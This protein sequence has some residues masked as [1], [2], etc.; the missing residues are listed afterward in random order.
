MELLYGKQM[1]NVS[2]EANFHIWWTCSTAGTVRISLMQFDWDI[3][4]FMM[5]RPNNHSSYKSVY[6]LRMFVLYF[7]SSN[8][9]AFSWFLERN[10]FALSIF[11]SIELNFRKSISVLI[12]RIYWAI[13]SPFSHIFGNKVAYM[14]QFLKKTRFP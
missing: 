9:F 12:T 14:H 3:I 5:Q 2:F 4:E 7:R 10:T 6:Q 11:I 8:S 1:I 13:S